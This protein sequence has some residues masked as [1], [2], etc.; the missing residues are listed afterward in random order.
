MRRERREKKHERE[1]R[2]RRESDRE[3]EIKREI[4][5]ERRLYRSDDLTR[6]PSREHLRRQQTSKR[7]RLTQVKQYKIHWN[8]NRAFRTV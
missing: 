1:R 2:E 8:N 5:K 3:K 7:Q 4:K 6:L